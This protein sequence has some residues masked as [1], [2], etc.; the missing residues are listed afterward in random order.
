MRRTIPLNLDLL[1]CNGCA[2]RFGPDRKMYVPASAVT[3]RRAFIP[4][5]FPYDVPSGC[6][7]YVLWYA[8]VGTNYPTEDQVCA[9]HAVPTLGPRSPS[10][11]RRGRALD[12]LRQM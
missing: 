1:S 6:R 12:R 2:G 3:P 8:G 10:D 4:N 5:Q 11:E 9:I 7:H